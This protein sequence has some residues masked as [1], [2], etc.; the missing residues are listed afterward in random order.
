M[1]RRIET[2]FTRD[3][4]VEHPIALAPMAFVAQ[5]PTFAIAVCQ[6][7]GLI[8]RISRQRHEVCHFLSRSRQHGKIDELLW[9]EVGGQGA[10][11]SQ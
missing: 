11:L 1:I 6:A 8:R 7:G 3:Y 10:F 2:R 4:G 5:L 9:V